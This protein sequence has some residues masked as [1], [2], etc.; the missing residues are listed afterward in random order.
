M[1]ANALRHEMSRFA[2]IM[3]TGHLTAMPIIQAGSTMRLRPRMKTELETD[4]ENA[5]KRSNAC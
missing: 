2:V 1:G 5:Q 3:H 4:A